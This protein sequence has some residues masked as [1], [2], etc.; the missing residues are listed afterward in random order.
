LNFCFEIRFSQGG[1]D[2]FQRSRIHRNLENPRST[3]SAVS[4][5]VD[6]LY[7]LVDINERFDR[8]IF[9]PLYIRNLDMTIMTMKSMFD[10]FFSIDNHI[11]D[12]IC[13]EILSRIHHQVH[14]LTVE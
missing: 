14:K 9:D 5:L 6:V 7:L 3:K 11:L 4:P 2:G 8:L 13:K 10:Q 12:N 1:T